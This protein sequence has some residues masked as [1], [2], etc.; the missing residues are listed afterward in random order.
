MPAGCLPERVLA[1]AD[2]LRAIVKTFA[3]A[4]MSAEADRIQAQAEPARAEREWRK[5]VI[6]RNRVGT[7]P[8]PSVGDTVR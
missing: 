2:L 7:V 8:A 6:A 4:L 1:S 5:W 3:D